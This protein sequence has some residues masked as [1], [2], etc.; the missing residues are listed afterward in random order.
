MDSLLALLRAFWR[1]LD[2]AR[3][4]FV[5]V[6]FLL[7]LVIIAGAL[8]SSDKPIVPSGVALVVAPGG[9]LVEERSGDPVD[10]AIGKSFQDDEPEAVLRD[11]VDAID[12]AR[13]DD[14]I[15][16]LVL[17]LGGLWSG[18]LP[19]LQEVAGA[20]DRFRQSGKPVIAYGGGYSQE[21]YLIAAHADEV[22]MDPMGLVL[23]EGYGS[24][25]L[26]YK[27]AI[28]KLG[29][30]WN[31][32]R[33]GEYKS[34]VE[35]FT[36][37]DMSPEARLANREWLDALWQA[38]QADVVAARELEPDAIGRYVANYAGEA[39]AKQGDLAA[40]AVEAR[41]VDKLM[42]REEARQRVAEI[43]GEDDDSH[44][45]EQVGV[46]EYLNGIR[47][48]RSLKPGPSDAIAVIVA[49]GDINDGDR[50]PGSVGGDST[51]RL[52]RDARFDDSV[53][54]I[55]LRVDSPGG[56]Q[57]A[58]EQIRRELALARA[59]GKPVI[60]S[61]S[62]VAASGGYWIALA[63]DEVWASPSTVTGS[64]G[65]FGM[66]P[67]F[68]ATLGKIGVRSD[69]VGTTPYA[70]ALRIDRPMRDEVKAVFQSSIEHGYAEFIGAVAEA[71]DL[72]VEKVDEL[73]RGRV[74]IGSKA[75]ELGLVDHLGGFNDA[76]AAAATAAGLEAGDYKLEWTKRELSFGE[77][78]LIDMFGR[79][80]TRAVARALAPEVFLP[81]AVLPRIAA[82]SGIERE[83]K[84]LA[85]F[86]DP[87][88]RYAYCFCEPR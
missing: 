58:S 12:T 51:S 83:L 15:E 76:V 7:L 30:N 77:R 2:F 86:N 71:R 19:K 81:Q 56:S 43:V 50:P 5:N 78:L 38:Y 41:L 65:I 40:I 24:W 74:W 60:V 39:V 68:E 31:V 33:V 8:L 72:P 55:V 45:F 14:R 54:A 69:G 48:E 44:S 66:F 46:A 23:L 87:A 53:K 18:S 6:I 85:S 13:D 25:Q 67:T 62:G 61:M 88:G 1:A 63:A 32:F 42:T 9:R 73:A 57:F 37:T 22:L 10:R 36:R 70:D 47:A 75:Q 52:V 3:R 17:D 35:P 4:L 49:A 16:A 80:A 28:D 11:L 20:V 64:I 34:Y 82:L 84:A 59:D 21:Q 27:E 26:Y 29:V 79:D